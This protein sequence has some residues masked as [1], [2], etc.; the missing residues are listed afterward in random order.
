MPQKG[1]SLLQARAAC[2]K[3][4]V[5]IKS[6]YANGGARFRA[7]VLTG[8]P[9]SAAYDFKFN[10]KKKGRISR[11]QKKNYFKYTG[12]YPEMIHHDGGTCS[13]CQ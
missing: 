8:D 11:T 12:K 10:C 7:D 1:F 3:A 6:Y 13:G 2:N 9:P 5:Y 4:K